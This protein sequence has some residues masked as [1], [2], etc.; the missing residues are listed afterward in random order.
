MTAAQ[1]AL[2]L[3]VCAAASVSSKWFPTSDSV[4]NRPQGCS[5]L[6]EGL[7]TWRQHPKVESTSPGQRLTGIPFPFSIRSGD[8]A[9]RFWSTISRHTPTRS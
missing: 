1:S 5:R 8:G 3:D 9:Y 7:W 4:T 2:A 6:I